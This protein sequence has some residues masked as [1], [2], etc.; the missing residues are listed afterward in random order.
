V[1]SSSNIYYRS[2]LLHFTHSPS[3]VEWILSSKNLQWPRLRK[4]FQA[5]YSLPRMQMACAHLEISSS[6]F[7]III[8]TLKG[9]FEYLKT[10]GNA[11]LDKDA[12]PVSTSS[13]FCLASAT[14]LV[15]CVAA[16]QC[17]ERGLVRLEED[18][19]TWL[20]EWKDALILKGF[21]T[22]NGQKPILEKAQSPI[23]LKFVG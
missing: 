14:K 22:D 12:S 16:M 7:S 4:R 8:N 5:Q 13:T 23:F 17:V 9:A 15:T 11:S 21:D 2:F 20:P 6:S 1:W 18:I 10:F 3:F 19:S